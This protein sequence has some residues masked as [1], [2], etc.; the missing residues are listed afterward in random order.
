MATRRKILVD[1]TCP[2]CKVVRQR[3]RRDLHR[4]SH[5]CRSCVQQHKLQSTY[6][7]GRKPHNEQTHTLFINNPFDAENL[8]KLPSNKMR[9]IHK[10]AIHRGLEWKLTAAFLD[11]LFT[12]QEGKCAL[13]GKP[14]VLDYGKNSVSIDRINSDLGYLE[15]NVQ[16]V[17]KEANFMKQDLDENE[18]IEYCKLIATKHQNSQVG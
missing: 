3:E 13:T 12:A 18:F 11:G 6:S 1:V 5:Y 9:R 15:N 14:L 8:N 7:T 4:Y 10:A 2:D 17:I 16:L